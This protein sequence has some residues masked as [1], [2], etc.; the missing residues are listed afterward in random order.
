MSSHRDDHLEKEEVIERVLDIVKTF[1]KV[2]PSKVTPNVHF[3][4]DLGM[5]NLDTVEIVMALEED[6]FKLEIPDKEADKIAK[7]EKHET[8][9]IPAEERIINDRGR[10]LLLTGS[11]RELD[12][13]S[14]RQRRRVLSIGQRKGKRRR[15]LLGRNS[16]TNQTIN[17]DAMTSRF[18]SV[19]GFNDD[20]GGGNLVSCLLTL[21]TGRRL[22]LGLFHHRSSRRV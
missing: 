5:A 18:P 17:T 3:Q 20:I 12:R 15:R 21:A 4:K 19:T 11:N 10:P 16:R 22:P 14:L 2:V 13:R 7:H 9:E 6:E 1:P 8:R